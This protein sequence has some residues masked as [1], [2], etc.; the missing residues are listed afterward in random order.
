MF[1][2]SSYKQKRDIPSE[3][4]ATIGKEYKVGM[5][6]SSGE[7][8]L[9]RRA[10][11]LS[12]GTTVMLKSILSSSKIKRDNARL[13]A[14]LMQGLDHENILKCFGVFESSTEIVLVLEFAAGGDLLDYVNS[15]G[16]LNEEEARRLF[17]QIT[18]AL[19]ETHSHG[20]AH[21]DVKLENILLRSDTTMLL[22]DFGLAKPYARDERFCSTVGTLS[23]AAP[24]LTHRADSLG[25]DPEAA[26][27]YALGVVLYAMITAHLPFAGS[28]DTEL[29]Q[30]V[31]AGNYIPLPSHISTSLSSL[32]ICYFPA[33]P[34][35]DHHYTQYSITNGFLLSQHLFR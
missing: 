30:N 18:H 1:A 20:I 12:S 11:Q 7:G 25:I 4:W 31:R 27:V 10:V 16:A 15:H 3:L 8:T 17:E 34:R 14:D 24:E 26:D 2:H 33:T 9:I 22:S 5:I 23:Y 13:E 19:L 32:C 35:N 29:R 21:R 6:V 28:T